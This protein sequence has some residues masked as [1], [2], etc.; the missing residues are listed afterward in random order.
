[1][2]RIY[3]ISNPKAGKIRVFYTV[4]QSV[5][6]GGVNARLDAMLVQF[7]LRI[8]CDE[9]KKPSPISLASSVKRPLKIDGIWGST[10]QAYLEAWEKMINSAY[11]GVLMDGK[12]STMSSGTT[13]GS[14]TGSRYKMAVLNGNYGMYRN[15]D[16]HLNLTSDPL[17]PPELTGALYVTT[18]I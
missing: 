1:M 10:S 2:P 3:G 16:W 6:K 18:T 9:V 15:I 4:D 8:L 14:T 13:A 12:V 11:A 5:G 17:W 7:F